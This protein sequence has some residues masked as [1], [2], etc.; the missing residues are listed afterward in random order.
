MAVPETTPARRQ[1]ALIVDDEPLIRWSLAETLRSDD[2]DVD[3]AADAAGA[4]RAVRTA[5]APYDVVVLDI[6]LPD[7]DGIDVLRQLRAL[8][9]EARV[10]MMS[11]H[12]PVEVFERALRL[13]AFGVV[14]KPFPL[15]EMEAHVA[16]ALS[17]AADGGPPRL[18]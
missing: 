15:V 8:T 9:P 13:G 14:A 5:D 7:G 17:S 18:H 2:L 16:R 12:A 4:L 6:R 3:Q 1:R 10:I 11:A